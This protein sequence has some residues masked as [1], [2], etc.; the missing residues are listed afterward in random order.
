MIRHEYETIYVTRPDLEEADQA[1]IDDKL[2]AIVD[3]K[4]GELLIFEQWGKRKLA[5]PIRNK[6]QGSYQYLHY[7][8]PAELPVELERNMNLEDSLIRYITVRLSENIDLDAVRA[9]AESAR[10]QRSARLG[11]EVDLSSLSEGDDDDSTSDSVDDDDDD[12]TSNEEG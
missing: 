7:A 11:L 5:Y 1:R 10:E 3:N 12:N 8:A 4:G 9:D 2:K 6:L